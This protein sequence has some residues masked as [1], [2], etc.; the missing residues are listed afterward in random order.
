MPKKRKKYTMENPAPGTIMHAVLN[1]DK[2]AIPTESNLPNFEEY[3]KLIESLCENAK[4][5]GGVEPPIIF[6]KKNENAL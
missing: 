5:V 6:F 3:K 4:T 2:N 1:R